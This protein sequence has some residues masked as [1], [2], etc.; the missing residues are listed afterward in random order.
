LIVALVLALQARSPT[1][2]KLLANV[3][4]VG[5]LIVAKAHV[6]GF[7][8]DKAR[9]PMMKAYNEG[10]RR[11]NTWKGNLS[12][13]AGLWAATAVVEVVSMFVQGRS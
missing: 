10:M 11:T 1:A 6:D 2:W 7:W 3:L 9:I 8:D 4:N 13:L 12:G 5:T